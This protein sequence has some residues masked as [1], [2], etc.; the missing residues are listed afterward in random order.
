MG[1]NKRVQ[2]SHQTEAGKARTQGL[3][4]HITNVEI[5]QFFYI[6][7]IVLSLEIHSCM[8]KASQ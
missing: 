4:Q 1:Q 5:T 7:F 3:C 2:N 6:S 8:K